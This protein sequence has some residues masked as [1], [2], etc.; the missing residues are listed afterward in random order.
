MKFKSYMYTHKDLTNEDILKNIETY[1]NNI[2]LDN[3][4]N[5]CFFELYNSNRIEGNTLDHY[6]TKLL[7]ED[8]VL[9]EGKG[10]KDVI[11]TVSLNR[12]IKKYMNI[13]NFNEEVL[14]EIHKTLTEDLLPKNESGNYRNCS[15]Y[16]S[17]S[18]HMPPEHTR[19]SDLVKE[20]ID[21]YNN[22][23]KNLIDI[24]T[25]K[26]K[27]VTIHPFVDGN[28][29]T[30]RII[31][32]GLLT[33]KGYPRLII[34]DSEKTLYYKSLEK[35]QTTFNISPWIRYSL[36]LMMYTYEN[37]KSKDILL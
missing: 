15:V 4:D 34:T 20:A 19:V 25:L 35:S 36:M 1:K 33:N 14:L 21:K 29:R 31:M 23:E 12:A 8:K 10:Y 37:L 24:F 17:G 3:F 7:L 30:T 9:P 27:L 2:V 26:Y 22:S 6:E 28:G 16:I 11:E 5:R 13:D 32:N 18:M